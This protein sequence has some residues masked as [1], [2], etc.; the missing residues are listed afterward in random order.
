[1]IRTSGDFVFQILCWQISYTEIIIQI[2]SGEFEQEFYNALEQYN[3]V[4]VD[5]AV[6]KIRI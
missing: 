5:L 2:N 3:N 4:S 1:M 6:L